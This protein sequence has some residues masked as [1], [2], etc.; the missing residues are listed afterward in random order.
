MT[1]A[2]SNG[3]TAGNDRAGIELTM[4]VG[5]FSF[6]SLSL[7]FCALRPD[8]WRRLAPIPSMFTGR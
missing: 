5:S 2:S 6:A 4:E 7:S 1:L 3:I 8:D